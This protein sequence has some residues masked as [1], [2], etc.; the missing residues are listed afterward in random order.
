[1][2]EGGEFELSIL[3]FQLESHATMISVS[4]DFQGR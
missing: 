4:L 3:D 2:A 1:M